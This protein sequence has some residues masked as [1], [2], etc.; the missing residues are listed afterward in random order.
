M[1]QG[2]RRASGVASCSRRHPLQGHALRLLEWAADLGV[3]AVVNL[4]PNKVH[5][6]PEALEA[7]HYTAV[8]ALLPMS[9]RYGLSKRHQVFLHDLD[10]LRYR[11]PWILD[12][13][14]ECQQRAGSGSRTPCLLA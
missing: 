6:P 13:R 10:R 1:Q 4:A 7:V 3:V 12:G 9:L 14:S 2:F 11:H 5:P 8:R